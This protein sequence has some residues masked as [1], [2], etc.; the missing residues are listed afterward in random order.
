MAVATPEFRALFESELTYVW[1]TLRRLGVPRR[2]LEDLTH[3]VFLGVHRRLADYD[4]TRPLRPWLFGFAFRVAS[5]YR[6]R[7][8]HRVERL[9][10]NVEA[11]DPRRGADEQM[12]EHQERALVTAALAAIDI[13]RAAVVVLHDIDGL[14]VPEIVD[15][16]GVPLNTLYSRLRIGRKEFA[17]AVRRLRRGGAP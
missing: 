3:D 14:S 10:G 5:D 7:A 2:D 6:R 13:D 11:S 9:E 17:D 16:L 12:V 15:V 1:N 4:A 8:R